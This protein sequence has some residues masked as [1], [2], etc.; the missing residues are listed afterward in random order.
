MSWS[1][2]VCPT[3]DAMVRHA[4]ERKAKGKTLSRS[5]FV[6]RAVM[7]KL[8]RDEAHLARG[9]CFNDWMGLSDRLTERRMV[10]KRKERKSVRWCVVLDASVDERVRMFLMEYGARHGAFVR[11]V[12]DAVREALAAGLPVASRVA[13]S[14]L[15]GVPPA[16]M[17]GAGTELR[18]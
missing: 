14:R 13:R 4:M 11:F 10:E 16:F 7:A 15:E 5:Q 8:E 3:I 1:L 18:I 17:I 9:L 6:Q 12:E 2:I